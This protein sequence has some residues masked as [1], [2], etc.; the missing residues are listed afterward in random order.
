M[1]LSAE[2]HASLGA[3]LRAQGDLDAAIEAYE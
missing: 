1:T 3:E 2:M